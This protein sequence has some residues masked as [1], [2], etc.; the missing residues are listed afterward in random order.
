MFRR[1][2]QLCALVVIAVGVVHCSGD[3]ESSKVKFY[4]V[5][6]NPIVITADTTD[7]NGKDVGAPWFSH[8][9]KVDNTS[10]K[11]VTIIAFNYKVKAIS[12]FGTTIK[13][14]SA[15]TASNYNFTYNISDDETCEYVFENFDTIS[16]GATNTFVTISDVP[17]GPAT[18][19]IADHQVIYFY[20]GGNP[21]KDDDKVSNYFYTV[22]YN[23]LGWF[24]G[25][26]DPEDRFEKQEF[27]FTQ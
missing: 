20:I 2:L 14:E 25:V 10:S 9:T 18:C 15:I 17:E 1:I 27:F 6:E 16:A 24:G 7:S 3:D 8:R 23:P 13:V 11:D 4:T 26:N 22:E 5:P 12:Q 21:N 19:P